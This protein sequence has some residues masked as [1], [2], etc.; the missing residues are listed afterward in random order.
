MIFIDSQQKCVP[1]HLVG[2]FREEIDFL[3]AGRRLLHLGPFITVIIC[4]YVCIT[5]I[6]YAFIYF[7][8]FSIFKTFLNIFINN[9]QSFYCS[10]FSAINDFKKSKN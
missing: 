6:I 3:P 10:H 2:K 4:V 9:F 7:E 8:N 5:V 1:W